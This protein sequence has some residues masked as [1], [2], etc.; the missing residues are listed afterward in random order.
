[1]EKTDEMCSVTYRLEFFSD[2]H[3]GSGL[4]AGA[5]VDALVIKDKNRLPYIPGKTIKGLVREAI[6][7][8]LY[9]SLPQEKSEVEDKKKAAFIKT[10]GYFNDD[11]YS[12]QQGSCFFT[13]AEFPEAKAQAILTNHAQEFLYRIQTSTAIDENGVADEHSLR[14]L[15]TVVPC[16]LQGMILNIDKNIVEEVQNALRMI[17]RIGVNRNRGLGR[18]CFQIDHCNTKSERGQN[19]I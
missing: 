8:L 4:A 3:C 12:G 17:K 6:V 16:E 13:N 1:M 15:E 7:D 2:W 11:D 14:R 5:D 10:F 18:C 19:E 9:L